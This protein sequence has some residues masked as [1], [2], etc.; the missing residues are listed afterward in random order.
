[1]YCCVNWA[2]ERELAWMRFRAALVRDLRGFG[3][4]LRVVGALEEF[5]LIGDVV[6]MESFDR[7]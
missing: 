5:G 4:E 7:F 3:G 6:D 1:M 2:E